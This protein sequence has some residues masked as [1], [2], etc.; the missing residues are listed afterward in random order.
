ME[1]RSLRLAPI[2][3]AL[4][5]VLLTSV[6]RSRI[7]YSGDRLLLRSV[8]LVSYTRRLPLIIARIEK[9]SLINGH[10]AAR[11]LVALCI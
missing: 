9:I 4:V 3:V 1:H 2:V 5:V 6:R 7:A 8:T 10:L 11:L